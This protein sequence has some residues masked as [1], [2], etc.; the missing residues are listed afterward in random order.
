MG[1]HEAT[2]SVSNAVG[3][4]MRV[5]PLGEGASEELAFAVLDNLQAKCALVALGVRQDANGDCLD[6]ARQTALLAEQLFEKPV[7]PAIIDDWGRSCS[8]DLACVSLSVSKPL[9]EFLRET[10]YMAAQD[11][12]LMFGES[13]GE[14]RALAMDVWRAYGSLFSDVDSH[15]SPLSPV[16][17]MRPTYRLR[18][19]F[20]EIGVTLDRV[21]E[22]F[23]IS[24]EGR[25]S[26]DAEV[27]EL[28]LT[29]SSVRGLAVI[30][31]M[32]LARATLSE[33]PGYVSRKMQLHGDGVDLGDLAELH[34]TLLEVASLL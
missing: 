21:F 28:S 26:G 6:N 11:L 27:E 15:V 14:Q 18:C 7:T 1:K 22:P 19:L 29:L 34:R 25:A 13:E 12:R 31:G 5:R 17:W 9:V 33:I 2:T 30:C 32:I 24:E 10:V 20:D 23:D 16:W 3:D 4:V 8:E